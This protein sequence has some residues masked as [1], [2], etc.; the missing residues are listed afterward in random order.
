M[1]KHLSVLL[2]CCL[3]YLIT[4]KVSYWVFFNQ[5]IDTVEFD[6]GIPLLQA[7]ALQTLAVWNP[8]WLT[9]TFGYPQQYTFIMTDNFIIFGLLFSVLTGLGASE[10]VALNLVKIFFN[11]LAGYFCWL[12]LRPTGSTAIL[13]ALIFQ[14][15]FFILNYS[16]HVQLQS[17]F[18][19]PLLLILLSRDVNRRVLLQI[20]LLLALSYFLSAYYF[21]FLSII[22][23]VW[24]I[25][26]FKK[27][28]VTD[29]IYMILPLA[30]ILPFLIPQIIISLERKRSAIDLSWYS[31]RVSYYF[32]F[33]DRPIYGYTGFLGY[34]FTLI[35]ISGLFRLVGI[36]PS[37]VFLVMMLLSSV[38]PH[39]K[40]W[41]SY[42]IPFLGFFSKVSRPVAVSAFI[43]VALSLGAMEGYPSLLAT[44]LEALPQLNS[45]RIP[46]RYFVAGAMLIFLLSVKLISGKGKPLV[47]IAGLIFFVEILLYRPQHGFIPAK[48]D[49]KTKFDRLF[50][51]GWPRVFD[52]DRV[53]Y[54]GFAFLNQIHLARLFSPTYHTFLINSGYHFYKLDSALRRLD[55]F[56]SVA[57]LRVIKSLNF[58]YVASTKK[59]RSRLLTLVERKGPYFLYKINRVYFTNSFII[60]IPSYARFA[61]IH[62][63]SERDCSVTVEYSQ[64]AE[65]VNKFMTVLGKRP[66]IDILFMD[67]TLRHKTNPIEINVLPKDCGKVWLYSSGPSSSTKLD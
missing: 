41:I 26:N 8:T 27:I 12:Y 28:Q 4:K 5:V 34:A 9:S 24:I 59:R 46:V 48:Y 10:T 67:P 58:D 15:C 23:A 43:L 53:N 29:L 54:D 3:C 64:S 2:C 36:F 63:S 66:K 17:H 56:P 38:N 49:F 50:I 42:L 14:S 13:F 18:L 61:K 44:C 51:Y 25:G 7:R 11:S 30:L 6:A 37:V 32:P 16:H 52:R 55:N 19:F 47:V 39:F 1:L 31:F 20:G 57:S 65:V 40:G 21:V 60:F 62:W 35:V 22:T 33:L 45:I